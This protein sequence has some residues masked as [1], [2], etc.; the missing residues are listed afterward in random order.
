MKGETGCT[1]ITFIIASP[2]PSPVLVKA[3]SP[4]QTRV[5]GMWSH[6]IKDII[7]SSSSTILACYFWADSHF[8]V[9]YP[10][11][12]VCMTRW[13]AQ[14]P[15]YRFILVT[16][17]IYYRTLRVF[18]KNSTDVKLTGFLP[19]TTKSRSTYSSTFSWGLLM[20]EAFEKNGIQRDKKL[21]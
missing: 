15:E 19:R 12:V 6:Y 4:H 14:H 5:V 16:Y 2:V 9:S 8:N 13:A 20:T 11:Q 3:C 21:V 1:D 10:D 7:T 18:G 17:L